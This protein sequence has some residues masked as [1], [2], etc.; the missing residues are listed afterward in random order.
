MSGYSGFY[1]SL[2]GDF[3][4][5]VDAYTYLILSIMLGVLI[6]ILIYWIFIVIKVQYG[7]KTKLTNISNDM[8]TATVANEIWHPDE[9]N[10]YNTVQEQKN[11]IKNYEPEK[12]EYEKLEIKKDLKKID[13]QIENVLDNIDEVDFE[14]AK[15]Y[16]ITMFDNQKIEGQSPSIADMTKLLKD[17]IVPKH[18]QKHSEYVR[19]IRGMLTKKGV[20]NSISDNNP[21]NNKTLILKSREE[22]GI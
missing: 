20:L 12:K 18:G 6:H 8:V 13:F 4:K 16:L 3:G 14:D 10:K 19:T 11:N 1:C 9:Q 21:Q 22:L 7:I 15:I 5:T 2:V 17:K